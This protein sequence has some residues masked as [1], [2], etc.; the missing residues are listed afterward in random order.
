MKDGQ[1]ATLFALGANLCFSLSTVYFAILAK[2]NGALWMNCFKAIIAF[3]CF[4]VLFIFFPVNIFQSA[5]LFFLVSG[6]IGLGIGDI[7]LIKGFQEIGPARTLILFSF[8]PII[9]LF[10]DKFFFNENLALNNILA[11]VIFIICLF[12]FAYENIKASKNWSLIGIY[13]ALLGI[14]LD[15]IGIFLS[16]KGFIITGFDGNT[17]NFIRCFG[18]ILFFALYSL[19]RPINILS[20]FNELS[21]KLK[22]QALFFSFLG[23]FLSLYLYLN[24]IK[25]GVLSVI[26]AISVTGPILSTIFELIILKKKP[27]R[28]MYIC[29]SLF[30]FAFYLNFIS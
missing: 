11:V 26:T 5:S 14:L 25:F 12:L 15:G 13:C 24:A 17:A 27:S 1:L 3:S 30:L 18:A 29:L 23:T 8:Q 20:K 19:N 22:K 4:L 2:K 10:I 9:F 21:P 7:F 6:F 28:I 16:K